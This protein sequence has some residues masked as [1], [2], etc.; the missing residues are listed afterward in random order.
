MIGVFENGYT[1]GYV[2]LAAAVWGVIVMLFA[3]SL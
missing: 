1:L 3:D 2:G